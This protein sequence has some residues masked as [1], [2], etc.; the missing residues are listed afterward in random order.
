MP[1][2]EELEARVRQLEDEAKEH[3]VAERA[4]T[5]LAERYR[6]VIE[7]QTEVISRFK[8]DGTFLFANEIYCRFFGK[9]LDDLIGDTWQP[10]AVAEDLPHIQQQLERLR[11]DN[12]D[13]CCTPSASC[14]TSPTAGGW[15]WISGS[16]ST[17]SSRG[18]SSKA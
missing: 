1:T 9:E 13:R 17:S 15:R 6:T 4:L 16:S 10:V 11:P 12:K 8:P 2:Y 7:D 18:K 3:R 14:T 5:D